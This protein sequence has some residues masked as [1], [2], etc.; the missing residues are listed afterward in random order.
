MVFKHKSAISW[1]SAEISLISF[2]DSKT[3]HI[4][5]IAFLADL[6]H[7]LQLT[8]GSD[9]LLFQFHAAI[10]HLYVLRHISY[11]VLTLSCFYKMDIEV[12]NMVSWVE[13]NTEYQPCPF[14]S[15]G[16]LFLC[17]KWEDKHLYS[18]SKLSCCVPV[19]DFLLMLVFCCVAW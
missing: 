16:K 17:F 11:Y 12:S 4:S 13:M 8:L 10:L 2:L 7:W 19:H 3:V 1:E 18:D 14:L 9:R 15:C 5:G 6:T